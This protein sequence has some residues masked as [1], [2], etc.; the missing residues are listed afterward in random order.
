VKVFIETAHV[1]VRRIL[2]GVTGREA[3][4]GELEDPEY[5]LPES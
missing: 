3:A 4:E 2:A 1:H 5:V